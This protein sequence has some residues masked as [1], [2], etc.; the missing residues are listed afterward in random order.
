LAAIQIANYAG[1]PPIALTRTSE[2]KQRLHEAG[3]PHVIANQEQ[4]MVAEVMRIT[5]GNGARVAFDPVRW[6]GLSQ[7]DR[8]AD[9]SGY[10][11]IY[12]ALS[13]DATSIPVL[14]MI[15]K[16]PAVKGYSIR[17]G[18]GRRGTPEG[19]SGVRHQ[20]PREWRAQADHRSYVQ[21][22]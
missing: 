21:V 11:H 18:D 19:R 20:G 8:R 14:E 3:A 7:A 2:K 4:D 12:G 6:P 5:V 15:R 1:A 10:R 13:E 17:L 9:L 22:R 16:T